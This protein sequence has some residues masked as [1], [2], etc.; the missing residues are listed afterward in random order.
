MKMSLDQTRYYRTRWNR[1]TVSCYK[2][3]PQICTLHLDLPVD[4]DGSAS[5]CVSRLC[6]CYYGYMACLLAA[7]SVRLTTTSVASG[8]DGKTTYSSKCMFG[9]VYLGLKA[10]ASRQAIRCSLMIEC[11]A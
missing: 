5:L 4:V 2:A 7:L 10:T 8:P 6:I 9:T 11:I 1:D 3:P